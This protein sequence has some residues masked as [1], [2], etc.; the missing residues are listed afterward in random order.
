ML[1]FIEILSAHSVAAMLFLLH[2]ITVR[3]GVGILII[4]ERMGQ[5]LKRFFWGYLNKQDAA[6]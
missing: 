5:S 2:G 3:L 6:M 4:T 1:T